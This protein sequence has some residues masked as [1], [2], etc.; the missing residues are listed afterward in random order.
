MAASPDKKFSLSGRLRSSACAFRGLFHA[1]RTQHNLWIHLSAGCIVT[2]A[3]FLVGLSGSEWCAILLTIAMV[4]TLEIM[5]TAIEKLVDIVSPEYQ[6]QAGLVK[7]I[8]AGA[9]L[10]AAIIAVAVGALIFIPKIL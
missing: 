2:V 6:K 8:A 4:I 1:A 10:A 5:N 7:D 9:V 3:G